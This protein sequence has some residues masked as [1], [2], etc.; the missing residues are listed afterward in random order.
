MAG[1]THALFFDLKEILSR[2]ERSLR[3]FFVRKVAVLGTGV[4]GAQ[5]AVLLVNAEIQVVLFGRPAHAANPSMNVRK[6]IEALRT[7][8]SSLL[9]FPD[10]ADYIDAANYAQYLSLL[11]DCDLIVETIEA[12]DELLRMI[13]P[14][15]PLHGIVA[16]NTSGLSVNRLAHCLPETLRS[17]F[18]GIHFFNPL[19]LMH[20]VEL[21]AAKATPPKLFDTL[22]SWIV[23]RLGKGIIRA[24]DT[25]NFVANRVGFFRC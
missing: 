21:V 3:N 25:P 1:R 10:Q 5:I 16:T 18:C 7:L 9:L 17:Q 15:V 19:R 11:K 6:T 13:A 8:E 4:M 23:S 24:H 22:E 20:L 12:K 14:W 2:R